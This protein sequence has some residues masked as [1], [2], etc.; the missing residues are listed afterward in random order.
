MADDMSSVQ[1]TD[2]DYEWVT[3]ELK[4][5]ADEFAEGR[6]VSMLEGGYEPDVLARSV[7]KHLDVLLG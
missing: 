1:L 6:I 2:A 4:A 3:R 5:V 7:V